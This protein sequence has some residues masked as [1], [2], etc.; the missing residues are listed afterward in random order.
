MLPTALDNLAINGI[1]DF[2]AH[3]YIRGE[4]P[5]YYGSPVGQRYL[6]F[7]QPIQPPLVAP[8]NQSGV[9]G[10]YPMPAQGPQLNPQP[11][12][13]GFTPADSQNKVKNKNLWV[14]IG[15]GAL[16]AGA[17]IFAGF[18]CKGLIK[19]A[20]PAVKNALTN[21]PNKIKTAFTG[22]GT[23]IK[24]VAQSVWT[25][26]VNGCTKAWKAVANAAKNLWSKIKP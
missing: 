11:T 18:K 10:Q 17:L 15:A 7:E 26:T 21:L 9:Q 14:K 24:N 12:Q 5:R 6:P 16:A 3:S 1:I 8:S 20:I 2:D 25:A 13:D 22:L 4:T 23:K 19:K